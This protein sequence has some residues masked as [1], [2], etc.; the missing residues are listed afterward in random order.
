MM[1]FK[2][3]INDSNY[4]NYFPAVRAESAHSKM[5]DKYLYVPTHK[6]VAGLEKAG[7]K[8]VGANQSRG[9][10]PEN[11]AAAKHQ[12]FLTPS[13]VEGSNM[14]VGQE[15]PLLALTNS[16]GGQS[17]VRFDNAFFRLVCSNGLMTMNHNYNMTSVAHRV[18]MEDEVIEAAW[19]AVAQFPKLIENITAMKDVTL[20]QDEKMFL[21]ESSANLAF[22]PEQIELNRKRNNDI[23]PKLLWS[24]RYEDRK[25]DLWT[26]FNVIQENV[27]KGGVKVFNE[28][29]K[30]QLSYRKTK[31]VGAIDRNTRLNQELMSLAEKMMQIK[32]GAA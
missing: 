11:R 21:A 6:L 19:A 24:R 16:H 3:G 27:I 28:T 31:Q 15:I 1:L 32:T 23:A 29:D 8:V 22:D 13:K 14:L 18:G 25:D 10:T 5:S 17:K 20:T 26:T 12:V 2:N 9:K 7:F 30:G 4:L